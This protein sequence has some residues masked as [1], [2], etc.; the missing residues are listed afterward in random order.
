MSIYSHE[1]QSKNWFTYQNPT[2]SS[3]EYKSHLVMHYV[4]FT[5]YEKRGNNSSDVLNHK[6]FKLVTALPALPLKW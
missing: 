5:M 1:D 2:Y 4:L 3:W 6:F